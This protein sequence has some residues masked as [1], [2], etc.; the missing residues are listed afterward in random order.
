MVWLQ[1][2]L[3]IRKNRLGSYAGAC[4][5]PRSLEGGCQVVVLRAPALLHGIVAPPI[6]EIR[7]KTQ[8][9]ID[10]DKLV[11]ARNWWKPDPAK[12]DNAALSFTHG[13]NLKV[14]HATHS[15]NSTEDEVGLPGKLVTE[16]C[17]TITCA[18][19]KQRAGDWVCPGCTG[20]MSRRA[21]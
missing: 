16:A 7:Q 17:S 11:P 4:A 12:G 20:R 14:H 8:A 13:A 19:P 21:R 5:T 15:G 9:L 18:W 10:T 3:P 2:P 6:D 1:L